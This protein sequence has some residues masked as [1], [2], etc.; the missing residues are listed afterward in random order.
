M[1]CAPRSPTCCSSVAI[2]CTC[3]EQESTISSRAS[4][5]GEP[6]DVAVCGHTHGGH[7]ALPGGVP[8]V[9][10]RPL[11]RRFSRGL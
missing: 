11:S 3:M 9:S 7:I 8:I 6:F 1:L 10:A 4:V 2:T 5:G